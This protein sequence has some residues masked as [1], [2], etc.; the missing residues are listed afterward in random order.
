M[1]VDD[2]STTKGRAL[3]VFLFGIIVEYALPG[4]HA[5]AN[6]YLLYWY[7]ADKMSATSLVKRQVE[8]R[9][10]LSP[11]DSHVSFFEL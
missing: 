7:F 4:L 11:V 9:T 8:S 3:S 5:N 1:N 6:S 2:N 10:K